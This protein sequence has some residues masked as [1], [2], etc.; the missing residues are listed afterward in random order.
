MSIDPITAQVINGRLSG[1]TLEM[2]RKLVRMSFSILFKESE[3][4]GCALVAADGWQL[5][6]A[7][8]TPLQM[9]P[10]PYAVQGLW[11]MLAERGESVDDIVP[12][13]V[14]IHNDAYKGSS[15]PPD[16]NI[17]VPV[18]YD[19]ALVG[20]SCTTG[21][22]LDV[23]ASKPGTSVIDAVDDWAC[24]VRL[25]GV[26]IRIAGVENTD[27]WQMIRDNVRIPELTIG[28]LRA[29]LAAAEIGARRLVELMDEMGCDQV[30]EAKQWAED[31]SEKMLRAEIAALPDG[32]YRAEGVSDGFPDSD[33][34]AHKNLP[35][36]CTL[37]VTGDELEV[38]LT[39][40]SPQLDDMAIN[41]PFQGTVM[42]V[43]LSV[44]RSVLLDTDTHVDIYQNQGILRPITVVAPEGSMANPTFPA[45]TLSR[46]MPACVLA[47]VIVKAFA[48]IVP[49]RC[50]AGISVL[51]AYAY[52]GVIDGKYWGHW[53]IY[54][55]S[56][57][58]RYAK[59]GMDAMDTLFTNTRCAPIEEI[60][61]EYPLRCM[62]WQL[63][64]NK[65]GHGRF[66]GGVG[67]RKDF[68]FLVDGMIASE[69]DTHTYEPW[70]WMGGHD[71]S[72]GSMA[73]WSEGTA[74][75][76]VPPKTAPTPTKAGEI[77]RA[78]SGNGGGMGPPVEREILRVE[79]DFRDD[80]VSLK[81]AEEVYGVVI[82]PA[83]RRA[84]IAASNRLRETMIV[85]SS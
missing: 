10:M 68:M 36:V 72:S 37:R 23:G 70:G 7:D 71:G 85:A 27:V 35:M 78:V 76:V 59:D 67:G 43:I 24:G 58:A 42:V 38:D 81:E 69:T 33:N 64:D 26:R 52:N 29:Q 51:G 75:R 17:I 48:Q 30:L 39:G 60:E 65:I 19:G 53:D 28:D 66:R 20:Y 61:T 12:G 45:P 21:H 41:M 74:M 18:F 79:R 83:T 73:V 15:H 13:D 34:P 11:E 54:E 9:G 62:G 50:C 5:S 57:G 31:Y 25:R 22:H 80:F 63:N 3:D 14:F 49:E 82:D 84:D 44:I 47:D 16:I 40:T 8:T 4:I 77:Y 32:V 55:G 46:S 2:S 1:I 6:E 56:Y